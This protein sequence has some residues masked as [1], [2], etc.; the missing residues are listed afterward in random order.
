[1]INCEF[2]CQDEDANKGIAVFEN[3]VFIKDPQTDGQ[4]TSLQINQSNFAQFTV[5]C[6][7]A[8]QA[9]VAAGEDFDLDDFE[10]KVFE[11]ISVVKMEDSQELDDN[12]KPIKTRRAKIKKYLFEPAASSA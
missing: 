3:F 5:A 1:M 10:R 2:R 8:T 7:V 12:G 4:K 9:Q 6:G 11:A